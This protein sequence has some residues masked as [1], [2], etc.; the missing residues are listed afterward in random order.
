MAVT[1]IHLSSTIAKVYNIYVARADQFQ[2]S[3]SS[4]ILVFD[5]K[6]ILMFD[7]FFLFCI[8]LVH[9]HLFFR[10]PLNGSRKAAQVLLLILGTDR[11]H[12]RNV[13]ERLIKAVVSLFRTLVPHL[14]VLIHF[15]IVLLF[16]L[17]YPV[18]KS[19]LEPRFIVFLSLPILLQFL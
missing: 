3:W 18:V 6:Y 14:N 12:S 1:S 9:A 17:S 11:E 19:L 7:F 4:I 8:E 15:D 16:D 13:Q 10:G 5:V 2:C